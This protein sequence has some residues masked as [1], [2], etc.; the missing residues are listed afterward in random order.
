MEA[1]RI[2]SLFGNNVVQNVFKAN[3]KVRI[4]SQ[5]KETEESKRKVYKEMV[6]ELLERYPLKAVYPSI[7]NQCMRETMENYREFVYQ[8][9]KKIAEINAEI[10]VFNEKVDDF[11]NNNELNIVQQKFGELF[12]QKH[13]KIKKYV[14]YN[15]E[16]QQD[17]IRTR[18][19]F[20]LHSNKAIRTYNEQAEAFC[21]ERGFVVK[22]KE[23]QPIKAQTEKVFQQILFCYN[24]QMYNLNKQYIKLNITREKSLPKVDLHTDE[25][26]HLNKDS[27][28]KMLD[29]SSR[30]IKR[31]IDRLLD[32]GVLLNYKF[33]GTNRPPKTHI[34]PEILVYFDEK[35]AEL[36]S[37]ENQA[38]NKKK[39]TICP[40]SKENNRSYKKKEKE[41]NS[42][43]VGTCLSGVASPLASQQDND[44]STGT[45]PS[46]PQSH[47]APR[48]KQQ[49]TPEIPRWKAPK[50]LKNYNQRLSEYLQNQTLDPQE[51]ATRLSDGDFDDYKPLNLDWLK[52]EALYGYLTREEFREL[53]FNDF[54][55][56]SAKLFRDKEVYVGCWL[57]TIYG[58]LYSKAFTVNGNPY[59]K[60][61][62]VDYLKQYRWRLE[63]ARRWF[64]KHKEINILFP[65]D[66]F[67]R[68]RKT[69]KEVGFKYTQKAWL[70][71]LKRQ[72]KTEKRNTE[73]RSEAVKRQRKS[74]AIR[75]IGYR[76]NAFV[77][78]KITY[79]ELFDYV[80]YNHPTFLEKLPDYVNEKTKKL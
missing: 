36:K 52:S 7:P 20:N 17:E 78:N 79:E 29:L 51:L 70:N 58:L 69:S 27:G 71:H 9:N 74:S 44:F 48:E 31:H 23:L 75:L 33:L 26:K 60:S 43:Q 21:N 34:N 13:G 30:T 61:H 73:K 72:E 19:E 39:E 45:P 32:A 54:F 28:I 55:K 37:L 11:V 67:D 41:A 2:G 68:N 76:I 56:N 25:I 6:D 47:T 62:M 59:G 63:Y 42:E 3:P 77:S 40:H 66:Y 46:N 1:T 35:T 5:D 80:K 64:S 14:S 4:A 15:S 12:Q 57:N 50:E 65:S 8:H 49:K 24:M 22:K 38:L 18:Y 16:T 53:I 10:Q